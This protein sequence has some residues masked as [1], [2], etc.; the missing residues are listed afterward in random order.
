M[1]VVEYFEE[2][3]GFC[4]YD[5]ITQRVYGY[6]VPEGME[7]DRHIEVFCEHELLHD[8]EE[9]LGFPRLSELLGQKIIEAG[10]IAEPDPES[11]LK[12]I[13]EEFST[14]SNKFL[15]IQPTDTEVDLD[16]LCVVEFNIPTGMP[17]LNYVYWD[18][19]NGLH[20]NDDADRKS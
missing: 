13:R 4:V 7:V 9:A 17:N 1:A 10:L 5:A 16:S 8:A 6:A 18:G 11:M 3:V 15:D 12:L 20:D 14:E 19:R 2:E